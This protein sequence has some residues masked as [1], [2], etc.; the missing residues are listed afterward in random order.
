MIL[1]YKYNYYFSI[2]FPYPLVCSLPNKGYLYQFL[3]AK[4]PAVETQSPNRPVELVIRVGNHA[5]RKSASLCQ[6]QL[7]ESNYTYHD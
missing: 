2:V 3:V 7:F 6:I 5:K 4:L 1:R